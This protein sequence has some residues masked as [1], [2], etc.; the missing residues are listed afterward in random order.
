M[1]SQPLSSSSKRPWLAG[2][3]LCVGMFTLVLQ[4]GAGQAISPSS[5]FEAV[6]D[7]KVLVQHQE[8]GAQTLKQRDLTADNQEPPTWLALIAISGLSLARASAP[9]LCATK[10]PAF[11]FHPI[12]ANGPRAPPSFLAL[13]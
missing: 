6:A 1:N 12:F 5:Q 7:I 11:T 13:G 8:K 4:L 9:A 10:L 3:L 2:L